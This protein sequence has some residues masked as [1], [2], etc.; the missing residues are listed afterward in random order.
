MFGNMESVVADTWR[1]LHPQ[2]RCLFATSC[3]LPAH[4]CGAKQ[5]RKQIVRVH[6]S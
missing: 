4:A 6:S 5:M 3:L 2:V 1:Q